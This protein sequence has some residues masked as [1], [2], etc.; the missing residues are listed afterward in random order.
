M[1][2]TT[3][4]AVS[5]PPLLQA[6]LLWRDPIGQLRS[7][8]RRHGDI[9]TLCL[10]STR[11][12]VAVGNPTAAHAILT[13]DPT[14]SRTG[15]ATGRVLPLLGEGC[16]LRQ[17]GDPHR[18]RRRLLNAV[19]HG[20]SMTSRGNVIAALADRELD[21]WRTGRPLAALPAMQNITFAV[22]ADLVLG[23]DDPAQVRHL[24]D[25]VRRLSTPAALAGT[26][27]SPVSDGW[28]RDRMWQRWL[29]RRTEVDQLLTSV[30]T[31]RRSAPAGGT[32]ALSLLLAAH[33]AGCDRHPNEQPAAVRE[34]GDVDADGWLREELLA[35]LMVGHETTATALGW[36]VERLARQPETA[37]RL[38]QS[39]DGG[40][41]SYLS[42]FISEVLRW[43]PPVVDA[44]REL[45]E[46]ATVLGHPLPAGTLVMVSPVLVHH[47]PGSYPEPDVFRPERFLEP[48]R[49]QVGDWIPFGGGRRHCLGAELA[50]FEMQIV[51][52]QLLKKP[53]LAPASRRPERSRLHGTMLVPSRGSRLLLTDRSLRPPLDVT[54]PPADKG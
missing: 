20:D 5:L 28:I 17:D 26:W 43:R 49:S 15:S 37:R 40:D 4:A 52:Q 38:A 23:I 18:Q 16:V 36:A 30:I 53:A 46:P 25:A 35:L 34:Q 8:S 10:P 21:R 39:L 2:L 29:G 27:M 1:S 50:V 54:Q 51:L 47:N 19:F 22:I 32:D 13:G 12:V 24:H 14:L 9:F 42:A 3:L 11:E 48:R 44:V 31:R 41:D 6:V 7:W 45:R 33:P